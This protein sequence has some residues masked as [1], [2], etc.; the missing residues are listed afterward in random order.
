MWKLLVRILD[1]LCVRYFRYNTMGE[2]PHDAGM[3]S[4]CSTFWDFLVADK[5]CNLKSG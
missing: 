2:L 4:C 5:L 1:T 3:L